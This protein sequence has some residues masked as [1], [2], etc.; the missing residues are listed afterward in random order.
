MTLASDRLDMES[1]VEIFFDEAAE[2]LADYETALLA[3]EE[4]QGDVEL[5]NRIF[6]AAHTI[7]G[8]AAMLGFERIGHFTHA[9]ESLLDAVRTGTRAVGPAV[10][11]ALL[12]AGDVLR[13]MLQEEQTGQS[14]ATE[15]D[16][17]RVLERLQ[18]LLASRPAGHDRHGLRA[19][20]RADAGEARAAAAPSA[21]IRVPSGR[22]IDSS[23]SSASSSSRSR[24]SRGRP[25]RRAM[26]AARWPRPSPTWIATR[27]TSTSRC[28]RCA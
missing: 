13:R 3:L 25:P 27:A 1:V 23:T 2:L 18:N 14:D 24:W 11:E 26:R 19:T 10:V 20:C 28:S 4:S 6:R 17:A 9:L 16:A 15:D 8:N 12:A 21:S 5:L 22:S 7:K